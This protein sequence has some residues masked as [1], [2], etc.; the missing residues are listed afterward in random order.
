MLKK[1]FINWLVLGLAVLV[2]ARII[3][4]IHVDGFMDALIA[5]LVLGLVNAF[6]R[7]ILFILTLPFTIITLGIFYLILNALLLLLVGAL[8]EGFIVN[9][10]FAAFFGSIFIAIVGALLH[11]LIGK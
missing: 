5:A 2:C 4:G 3:P 1:F 11:K 8:V 9:G 6:V 7:P 10:F